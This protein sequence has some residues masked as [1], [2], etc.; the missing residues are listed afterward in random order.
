MVHNAGT[1]TESPCDYVYS[2]DFWLGKWDLQLTGKAM[3]QGQN[4]SDV[5]FTL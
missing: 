1:H 4:I 2:Q 5:R 3:G